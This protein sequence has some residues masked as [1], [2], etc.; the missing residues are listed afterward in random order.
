MLEHIEAVAYKLELPPSSSIHPVFHISQLRRAKGT[1]HSSLLLPPQLSADLELVIEPASLLDVCQQPQGNPR[2]LELLI[3]W[4]NL[5][6]FE[7]TWENFHLL[8]SKFP[9]FHLKDKVNAWGGSI[10]K[11]PIQFTYVRHKTRTTSQNWGLNLPLF[12]L[13]AEL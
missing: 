7:A 2:N 4:E 1:S 3:Q 10:D 11:P 9:A 5:P 8:N 6:S 12:F 13:L